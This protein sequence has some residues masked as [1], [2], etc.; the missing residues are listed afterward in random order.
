ML[1]PH[2]TAHHARG[3]AAIADG[4]NCGVIDEMWYLLAV[5]GVD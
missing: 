5:A 1:T 3:V 2:L 4:D